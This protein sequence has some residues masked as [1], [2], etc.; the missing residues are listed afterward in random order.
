METGRVSVAR[1][2]GHVTYPARVQLVAAM[3]PC[4][5]GRLAEM[6]CGRAPRCAEEY[7]SR[8]SGPLL[9]RLD[10][11]IEVPAVSPADLALPPPAED[12]AAIARRVAAAR[13]RQSARYARMPAPARIRTNAEADGALLDEIATPDAAGRAL[14]IRAAERLRLSARGYHRVLRVARTLA[15]LEG[16]AAVTRAHIAEAL[17]YRPLPALPEPSP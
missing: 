4:R 14:L 15:D 8:L 10:L 11:Q 7:Q 12:S 6:A 9:D 13:A 2:H 1:A 5:C 17:S 16:A 3:N